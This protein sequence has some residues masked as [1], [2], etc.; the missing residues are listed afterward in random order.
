MYGHRFNKIVFL[1][2]DLI[3]M[4][5]C[6]VHVNHDYW[7]TF[8]LSVVFGV[9]TGFCSMAGKKLFELVYE[10]AKSKL[11]KHVETKDLEKN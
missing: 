1:F 2:A 10:M 6:W 7:V 9:I 3:G 4:L 11:K 5:I 8:W